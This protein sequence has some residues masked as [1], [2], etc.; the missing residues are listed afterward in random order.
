MVNCRH[1]DSP[2]SHTFLDL[3]HAPP[4]NAYL[5]AA[6]LTRPETYYPLRTRV[7]SSCWLVQTDD[8]AR[9]DELFSSDYAYFSSTSSGWLAHAAAYSR[10]MIRRFGLTADRLV[11]EVASNDGYLLRNFVEAGIPC[12]G[13]EP[14]ASTAAA[15]EA[16]VFPFFASSSAR[17]SASVSPLRG[18]RPT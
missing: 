12:L 18:G 2:V 9:A 8:Y 11:V 4:S 3:G 5:S 15:A 10:D 1:C 6:D 16:A 13:I 17:L 7:C 14:T